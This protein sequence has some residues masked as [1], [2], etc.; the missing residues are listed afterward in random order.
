MGSGKAFL[1]PLAVLLI[2]PAVYAQDLP[3]APSQHNFWDR[4][5]KTLFVI[6]AGL[7]AVDF[8]IT[9]R[10]LSKG[11]KELNPM[12]KALCESGTGGQIV[13][14]GGRTAAVL[15]ISYLFHKTAHH[16]MERAFMVLA[17]GDSA[18][19]ATYSFAHR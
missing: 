13:F 2:G 8:G 12:G 6:H 14:F 5:N 9:H 10:N 16:K 18:F 7:E 19:G 3:D 4:T 11:G 1:L 17:S 15:G